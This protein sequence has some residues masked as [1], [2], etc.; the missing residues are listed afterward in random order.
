MINRALFIALLL[1]LFVG[2]LIVTAIMADREV[3][4]VAEIRY[5]A[6]TQYVTVAKPKV[7]YVD[8]VVE[9]IV[10]QVVEVP[11]PVEFLVAVP[12]SEAPTVQAVLVPPPAPAPAPPSPE[13]PPVTVEPPP[14]VPA[15]VCEHRGKGQGHQHGLCRR[16]EGAQ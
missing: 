2:A 9:R 1:P 6:E 4:T 8:R 13:P 14:V 12:P 7:V 10:P 3:R 15:F 5:V 11:V 16:Q